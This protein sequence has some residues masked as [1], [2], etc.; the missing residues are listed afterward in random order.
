MVSYTG[1]SLVTGEGGPF[2]V[3]GGR[4]HCEW[5]WSWSFHQGMKEWILE[6]VNALQQR[7]WL[8][9]HVFA[10]DNKHGATLEEQLRV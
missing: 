5:V 9:A 2:H 8:S 4:V 3:L 1:Y 6:I 7:D 10:Q